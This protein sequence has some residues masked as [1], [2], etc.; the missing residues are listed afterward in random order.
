MFGP[1]VVV[2]TVLIRWADL[3]PQKHSGF[4][5]YVLQYMTRPMQAVR[6][7]GNLVMTVGAWYRR[8]DL[9]LVG[10]LVILFG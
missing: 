3:E 4:G 5:R 7:A 6:F 9:L 1:V 8:A 10:L 2:S